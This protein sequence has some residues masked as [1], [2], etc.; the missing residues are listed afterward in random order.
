MCVEIVGSTDMVF[1]ITMME[2]LWSLLIWALVQSLMTLYDWTCSPTSLSLHGLR[3][4]GECH[5]PVCAA[6]PDIGLLSRRGESR[7]AA[8]GVWVLMIQGLTPAR[9]LGSYPQGSGE[10][11]GSL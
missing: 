6:A 4:S 10:A 7:G 5:L 1:L 9:E 3:V 8:V 11:K 2:L